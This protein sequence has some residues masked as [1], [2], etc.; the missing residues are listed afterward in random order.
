MKK[1]NRGYRDRGCLVILI[2]FFSLLLS[3]G[4]LCADTIFL[5]DGNRVEGVIVEEADDCVILQV[6]EDKMIIDANN[7]LHI[8]RVVV[9]EEM[10]AEKNKK[11]N[12]R[13]GIKGWYSSLSKNN[14]APIRR[15]VF[16]VHNKVFSF[17]EKTPAYQYITNR[18]G[19][20]KFRFENKNSFFFAVYMALLLIFSFVLKIVCGII[21]GMLRKMYGVERRYDV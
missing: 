20:K 5:K 14:W 1:K 18:E 2:C 9:S 4:S 7:I 3:E 8:E 6:Q 11:K 13:K 15:R 21:M 16:Y 19:V 10:K 17:L 12:T